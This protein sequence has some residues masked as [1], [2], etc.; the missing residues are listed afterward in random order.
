MFR[1]NNL[2]PTE[3][4]NQIVDRDFRK[5]ARYLERCKKVLWNR[6]HAEYIRALRE[7][8]NLKYKANELTVKTGDAVLIKADAKYHGKWKMGIVKQI[9][10]GRDRNARSVKLKTG[11]G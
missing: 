8:H 6:W 2:L 4:P 5:R 1:K 9:I 11:K 3:D 7:R 10:P